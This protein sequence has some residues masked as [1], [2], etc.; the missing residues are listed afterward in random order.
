VE[1]GSEG[2]GVLRGHEAAGVSAFVSVMRGCDQFC[3]YCIVPY[4]RGR[5][6]SRPVAD[7]AEE[8]R[9]LVAGG[10]R[11]V[12]LLGQNITAYG[13]AEARREGRF[14]PEISPFAELLTVVDRVGGVER[15]R[16][17]SPHPKYMNEAF[18]A[19]VAGL[20]SVCESFHIPLQSGSDRVLKQMRRGYTRAGYLGRL[21]A[22]R[23]RLPDVTFSTDVIVGFPGE[24]E[25]DFQATRDVM[26]E[27]GFDMAYIFKYSPRNGTKAA[28]LPDD[29]PQ[30]VKEERNRIL[31]AD[32]ETRTAASNT[33]YI[34]ATV[35]VL[36]EGPSKRNPARWQGRTRTNKMCIFQP[37]PDLT[38]GALVEVIVNRTTANSLFG[39]IV[40]GSV[41]STY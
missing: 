1:P 8:V 7:V 34:G 28:E 18:V 35:E 26:D 23:S 15:I 14:T 40:T 41:P 6:K 17:T 38:P 36:A 32:L 30:E 11:E 10:T 4:V 37:D 21:E 29:V 16:F 27:V 5:E 9:G 39:C 31:L 20:P 22:I 2:L 13:L 19:A 33:R 24:G 25:A 3:T 12:F